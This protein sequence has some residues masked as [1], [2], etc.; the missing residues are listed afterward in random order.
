MAGPP[1][2]VVRVVPDVPQAFAD[3]VVAESP[4]TLVLSGGG[5]AEAAY[6]ALAAADGLHWPAVTVL[7][8]DERFVPVDDPASNEGMAR[9]ALLDHVEPAAVQLLLAARFDQ[10]AGTEGSA[11]AVTL[12]SRDLR[13]LPTTHGELTGVVGA[14]NLVLAQVLSADAVDELLVR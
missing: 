9:R 6:R 2:G 4:R 10:P 11:G 3:L 8:G 13:I 5:T 1:V 7:F 14:A 12:A